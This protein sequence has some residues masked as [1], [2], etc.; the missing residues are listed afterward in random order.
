MYGVKS[1]HLL[2]CVY[3]VK[4]GHLLVCVYGV[5]TGH[6]LVCVYGVETN[7]CVVEK[8]GNIHMYINCE[9]DFITISENGLESLCLFMTGCVV[10]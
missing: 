6:L 5:K 1:G 8:H 4:T 7:C 3:G 9:I 2:V 10:C